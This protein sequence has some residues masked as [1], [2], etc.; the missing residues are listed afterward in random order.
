MKI[1]LKYTGLILALCMLINCAND[2]EEQPRGK[3][4]DPE[5]IYK[6][7]ANL[8]ATVMAMYAGIRGDANWSR[9]FATSSYMTTMFGADDL[10]TQIGGNKGNFREFDSF[11]TSANN[12]AMMN[13]W[14][15]CYNAILNANE[16]IEY[17]YLTIGDEAEIDNLVGQ[18]HFVRAFS[19]FYLVRSW[20]RIPLYTSASTVATE[21][22][23]SEVDEVYDVM[24]SDL[25]LA[26][27]LLP[28]TQNLV[29]LPSEGAAKALLSE[30]YLTQA[31]WPLHIE[32][33][34]ALAAQKAKEVIDNKGIYGY[35]LLSSFDNLWLREYD[36][37]S[38]SIFSLQY[39]NADG[40]TAFHI[41]GKASMPEAEENGWDDFF[42]ELNFF[43]EFPEG[44]RKDATFR[45]NF[46]TSD[47][48]TVHYT[49]SATKHPYYAKFRDGAVDESNP[50]TATFFNSASYMLFRYAEVLLIYAEAQTRADGSPNAAAYDALN[51]VRVRAG[52]SSLAGL[53]ADEFIDAVIDEKGWELAGE[54]QRWY[55]L[56]RTEKVAEVAA[57][58]SS[59]EQVGII[60]STESNNYYAP[61]PD[62]EILLNPNLGN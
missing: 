50:S 46:L 18:A 33:S 44:P 13:L 11:N 45:T 59:E 14:R 21:I 8:E 27:N 58:R 47:G 9:G 16:V 10:T 55:D 38:E 52:L 25:L 31:G 62:S 35:D 43:N 61:I 48:T 56:I 7:Y 28:T 34:Y 51:Q 53:S 12:G 4:N 5:T 36:N 39:D 17:S 29:G 40:A 26:E 60:G 3:V 22:G 49:N 57:N 32:S 6:Q 15:G 41:S 19:Y 37:S 20:G 1:N 30:V 54:G 24:I 42:V 2:L 23:L